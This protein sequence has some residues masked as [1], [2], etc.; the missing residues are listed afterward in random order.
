MLS[1][2]FFRQT[3]NPK[4]LLL[5]LF[6]CYLAR[7]FCSQIALCLCTLLGRRVSLRLAESFVALISSSLS[8]FSPYAFIP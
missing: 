8:M 6:S 7:R 3:L 2:N 1:S 4:S 5:L